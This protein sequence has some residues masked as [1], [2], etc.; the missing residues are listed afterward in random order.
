MKPARS[1]QYN[2]WITVPDGEI[3]DMLTSSL[4]KRGYTIGPLGR[5]LVLTYSD[6]PACVLALSLGR[7]YR[8]DDVDYHE[9]DKLTV[10]SV[11]DEVL[12]IIKLNKFKFFSL[13]VTESSGC[14]WNIGNMSIA[15]EAEKLKIKMN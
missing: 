2:V 7:D 3:I 13:I 5:R 14:T 4:V 10:S 1:I 6:N 15:D 8:D 9:D 11:Y 12:N